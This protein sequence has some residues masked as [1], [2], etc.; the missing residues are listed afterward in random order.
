[1]PRTWMVVLAAT[2]VSCGGSGSGGGGGGDGKA[3]SSSADC[4][5]GYACNAGVCA[6][7]P[8][9][10]TPPKIVKVS[11]AY[12]DVGTSVSDV[13]TV[14]FS[15]P[16]RVQSV[17]FHDARGFRYFGATY[18]LS[19]D[20]KTITIAPIE[21]VLP[22][23]ADLMLACTD[24]A[25]NDCPIIDVGWYFP[26]WLESTVAIV[27]GAIGFESLSAA[28]DGGGVPFIGSVAGSGTCDGDLRV[29]RWNAATSAWADDSGRLPSDAAV[30]AHRASVAARG[31]DVAVAWVENGCNPTTV[32]VAKR[33]AAGS[34]TLVGVAARTE[35]TWIGSTSLALDE[36]GYPV[37]AW[38]ESGQVHAARWDGQAWNAL[39]GAVGDSTLAVGEGPALALGPGDVPCVAFTQAE[40]TGSISYAVRAYCWDGAASAWEP[41]AGGTV[42]A[43]AAP[44]RKLSKRALAFDASGSPFVAWAEARSVEAATVENG[45]WSESTIVAEGYRGP[46]LAVDPQLGVVAGLASSSD[47]GA[48]YYGPAGWTTLPK[49]FDPYDLISLRSATFAGG[50]GTGLWVAWWL[51]GSSNNY[52]RAEHY[53][54]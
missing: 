1:M 14:T 10:L 26:A 53:N 37:V 31:G 18:T 9:D 19:A 17:G 41:F 2:L 29:Y 13:L 28:V 25:G 22:V 3:C 54:K 12:S 23:Y 40:T 47:F 42:S 43:T 6:A 4:P 30:T 21:L 44:G 39:G 8:S 36:S 15:E 24:H 49:I 51:E 34:W 11:P 7:L 5:V 20:E 16:I 46:E 27:D 50:P 48:A 33:V 45:A 38:T 32:R 35:A 52:M